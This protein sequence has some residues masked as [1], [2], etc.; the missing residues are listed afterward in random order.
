MENIAFDLIKKF[1]IPPKNKVWGQVWNFASFE[2]LLLRSFFK[3]IT[4]FQCF[5]KQTSMCLES[6]NVGI[7][8]SLRIGK[9]TGKVGTQVNFD[10]FS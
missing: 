5:N 10:F 1:P 9:C 3:M 2:F 7:G 8:G 6:G 4:N